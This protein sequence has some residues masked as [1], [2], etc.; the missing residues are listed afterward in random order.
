MSAHVYSN[1]KIFT[2]DARR[3]AE[4]IVVS[5]QAAR[6]VD[7]WGANTIAETQDRMRAWAADNPDATRMLVQGWA[8]SAFEGVE[9]HSEMLDAVASDRPVYA[10]AYD[11]HFISTSDP[12]QGCG[13]AEASAP[14]ASPR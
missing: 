7:R 8:H 4:A 10:Q 12:V 6:Q 1:A 14:Q 9:P 2:V 5:G 13:T 11:S 3:W